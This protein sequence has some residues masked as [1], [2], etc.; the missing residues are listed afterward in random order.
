MAAV[1]GSRDDRRATP[2][3]V[4]VVVWLAS[5]LMFFA[6][7]F[8]A[9]FTLRA[10][11]DRWPPS[12]VELTTGRTAIAT[13][14]LVASSVTMHGATKAAERQDRRGA[15]RWLA[16]TALLGSVFLSN[17]ALEYASANFRIS[18]NAYGSIFYLMTG[19]HGLH[20]IGGLLFMG[21]VA[22]AIGGRT[23]KMPAAST[24]EVCA[25]YW[26]F[27]DVVWVAMFTTIYV[28]K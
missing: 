8:A 9:Y 7:L 27:V 18:T 19:F 5:E 28:L 1:T 6:G 16:I 11:A 23:S 17:Q 2:L 4:G 22:G 15:V 26:H 24:V 14:V 13:A 12:G 3:G 25:Y 20:V 10:A 21:A